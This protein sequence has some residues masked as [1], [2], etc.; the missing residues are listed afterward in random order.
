MWFRQSPNRIGNVVTMLTIVSGRIKLIIMNLL[1]QIYHEVIIYIPSK[2][3]SS[4]ILHDKVKK[5][6]WWKLNSIDVIKLFFKKFFRGQF[7][8]IYSGLLV[9]KFSKVSMSSYA[10]SGMTLPFGKVCA[11]TCMKFIQRRFSRRIWMSKVCFCS[12]CFNLWQIGKLW[13]VVSRHAEEDF[14]ETATK[15]FLYLPS[16]SNADRLS[17]SG[18]LNAGYWHVSAPVLSELQNCVFLCFRRQ[19]LSFSAR[20]QDDH[21]H[22]Q[23]FFDTPHELFF[24]DTPGMMSFFLQPFQKIQWQK[25]Q[26]WNI[27]GIVK[28][29][30]TDKTTIGEKFL[31]LRRHNTAIE[32][33]FL[34]FDTHVTESGHH[35]SLWRRRERFRFA[36]M[37]LHLLPL[38]CSIVWMMMRWSRFRCLPPRNSVAISTQ[39][40]AIAPFCQRIVFLQSLC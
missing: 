1:Y 5:I 40:T 34:V 7:S 18:I 13:A 27:N 6:R 38:F 15:I 10:G 22:E 36:C 14:I 39:S 30:G 8:R 16:V 3:K 35:A 26:V 28:R 2:T 9:H 32:W 21:L 33:H 25:R 17:L 11:K 20:T 4:G 37:F 23:L 19:C 29:V 31:P 24:R 12:P